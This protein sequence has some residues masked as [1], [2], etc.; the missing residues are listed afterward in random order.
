MKIAWL[1]NLEARVHEAAA[2]LRELRAANREL[3]AERDELKDRVQTL[4]REL[5]AARGD[6]AGAWEE[7][8]RE[9]RQRVEK[10]VA[11]LES[12]LEG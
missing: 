10:L 6:G 5:A 4:E 11:H 8:R 3:T 7:E 12:L 9:V 1:K 2:R